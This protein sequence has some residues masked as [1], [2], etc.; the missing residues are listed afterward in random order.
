MVSD[1]SQLTDVIYCYLLRV[2]DGHL[3]PLHNAG[4]TTNDND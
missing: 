4:F 1:Q 2:I 3:L